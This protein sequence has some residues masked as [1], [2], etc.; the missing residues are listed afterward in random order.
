MLKYLI[1]D[2]EF[3][4]ISGQFKAMIVRE[5]GFNNSE[6]IL[7]E[8]TNSELSIYENVYKYVCVLRKDN[9][10]DTID[11]K[12]LIKSGDNN[13]ILFLGIVK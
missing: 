11:I 7:R 1:N 6:Q 12:V 4:D 3:E 5:D 2:I 9:Y 8:K 10:C 13:E